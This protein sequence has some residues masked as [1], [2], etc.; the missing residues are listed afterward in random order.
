MKIC[1][2]GIY[3]PEY[4]RNRILIYGLKK[5]GHQII[6]CNS[7]KT[8]FAAYLE[9]IKKHKNIKNKYDLII[10]PFPSYKSVIFARSIS[11]RP[12]I[13]D[14]FTS[15][16]DTTVNDRKTVNKYS[17]KA[18]Y[19]Y[20]LDKISCQLADIVLLD[21]N[22]HINYLRQLL[23]IKKEKFIRVLV[24]ADN[25]IFKP[26]NKNLNSKK[27]TVHFH[28]NYIPLQGV[29][30]IVK[31]AKLLE[32]QNVSFNIIGSG[33]DYPAVKDLA[34]KINV[35]NINFIGKVRY[36]ELPGYIHKADVCLGIFGDTAKAKRVIPNKLYEGLACAKPVITGSSKAMAEVLK[37]KVNIYTC[38]FADPED[39]AA[40][41]L[42][43]KNNPALAR[44]IAEAGYGL[45]NDNFTPEVIAKRLIQDLIEK[46]VINK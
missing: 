37:N 7:R 32:K 12:I 13:Y 18:L 28:G 4:S 3:N 35:K 14:I 11:S 30:Y 41:I 40:K 24:G 8:G 10:V 2:F 22:E 16:Y 31:A 5:N 39:L 1:F 38:F 25:R 42:D 46:G 15:L 44:K 34:E 23:K 45:F 27:F 33:Q 19:Y 43:L 20:F 21:T 9:L 26:G 17:L 36:A 29:Q 6:E